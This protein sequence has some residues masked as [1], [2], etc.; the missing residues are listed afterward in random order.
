MIERR[1]ALGMPAMGDSQRESSLEVQTQTGQWRQWGGGVSAPPQS[2][3]AEME[4]SG[5]EA[6][7]RSG[8]WKPD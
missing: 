7:Q 6:E 4:R 3:V 8:A 5:T 2:R 1:D